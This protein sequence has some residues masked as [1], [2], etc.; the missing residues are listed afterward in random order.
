MAAKILVGLVWVM[1]AGIV[2]IMFA[3]LALWLK[4]REK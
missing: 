1:I 4:R 2:F 3:P